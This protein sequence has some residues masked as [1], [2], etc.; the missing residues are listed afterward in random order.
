MCKRHQPIWRKVRVDKDNIALVA[1]NQEKPKRYQHFSNQ[2][3]VVCFQRPGFTETSQG[4]SW[5]HREVTQ[6]GIRKVKSQNFTISF[7]LHFPIIDIILQVKST[8]IVSLFHKYHRHI[9][10][11]LPHPTKNHRT[12]SKE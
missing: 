4:C 10:A 7:L 9:F 8:C 6:A 2:V 3:I 1:D 5:G 11:L 12:K